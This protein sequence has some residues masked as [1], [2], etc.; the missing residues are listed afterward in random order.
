M[1]LVRQVADSLIKRNIQRLTSTYLTLSLADIA[2]NVGPQGA[3][4]L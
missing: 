4:H 2:A 3:A 1:G